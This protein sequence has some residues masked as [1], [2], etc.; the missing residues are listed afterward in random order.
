MA[1]TAKGRG[2]PLGTQQGHPQKPPGVKAAQPRQRRLS[3]LRERRTPPVRSCSFWNLLM[4]QHSPTGVA[5]THADTPRAV[6]STSTVTTL[7]VTPFPPHHVAPCSLQAPPSWGGHDSR[8][9]HPAP[10][11][12]LAAGHT[13]PP[14]PVGCGEEEEGGKQ[15]RERGSRKSHLALPPPPLPSPVPAAAGAARCHPSSLVKGPPRHRAPA[16][17]PR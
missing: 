6:A 12:T 7:K 14:R 17:P 9:Q 8:V 2:H 16:S 13:L 11:G 10:W 1:P 3:S 15:Q 5:L 4:A